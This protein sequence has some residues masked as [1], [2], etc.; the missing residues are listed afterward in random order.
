[1]FMYKNLLLIRFN[2]YTIF[3]MNWQLIMDKVLFHIVQLL[4]GFINFQGDGSL[5]KMIFEMIVRYPPLLNDILMRSRTWWMMD[6]H[7][8]ID[9]I[10]T[11][12]ETFH[13]SN[14][15]IPYNFKER[16]FGN[17]GAG[18]TIIISAYP[19]HIIL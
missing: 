15:F 3:M 11:I 1:M 13:G 10:G 14:I 16:R 9:Y 2:C 12:L 19:L 8:I 6:P 17:V 4:I 5:Y 7:S 18:R